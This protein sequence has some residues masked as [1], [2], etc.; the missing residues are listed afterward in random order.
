MKQHFWIRW[1]REYVCRLQ[2]RP[3]WNKLENNIKIGELV[4]IL[5]KRS[6]PG[7]WSLARVD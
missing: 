1:Q 4:L 6:I 2:S 5:H 3:K 7:Q